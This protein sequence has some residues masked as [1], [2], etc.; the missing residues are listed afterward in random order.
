MK[1][2]TGAKI[3]PALIPKYVARILSRLEAHGFEAYIVGGCVRDILR[4]VRPHDW[5]I[6]SSALP[7]ELMA[8]FPR[9]L[10]TGIKH[11]TVTVMS[12]KK[13]CEVTTFRSDGKYC[14]HRRPESVVFLKSLEGDL[15][16][17][18][19]TMNA[20]ACDIRGQVYDYHGGIAD[21]NR[22]KI[23]CVGDAE[24]RFNEDALR[25]LRAYR[26]SA[27]LGFSLD[28][29]VVSA[30]KSCC[31]LCAGLSPERVN[32]ELKKLL[33]SPRP[34]LVRDLICVG[35]LASYFGVS[36]PEEAARLKLMPKNFEQRL[37]A[38]CTIC[39]K[40]PS[41]TA[42]K[43]RMPRKIISDFL[44]AEK[45]GIMI[46]GYGDW[47]RVIAL[48]G[49][50]AALYFA[51]WLFACG[52]AKALRSVKKVLSSGECCR[53]SELAFTGSD[54]ERL[55]YKG[56]EVGKILDFLLDY[57]ITHPEMNLKSALTELAVN[58]RG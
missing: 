8:I 58:K 16:R 49:D 47:K 7:E 33:L 19:F 9:A 48:C 46:R 29:N 55:G 22:K 24:K 38:L 12:A 54:A 56:K 20:I 34:Y 6:C 23:R 3:S 51:A 17:R 35:A 10:P 4:G 50:D 53:L 18:D 31:A 39:G 41:E 26:F 25:I 44:K 1:G 15:S 36:C 5:D 57:V 42:E 2:N 11:G 21:I 13:G 27:Q 43:L 28:E 14:D 37:Y 52:D 45:C 32:E 40:S 30:A